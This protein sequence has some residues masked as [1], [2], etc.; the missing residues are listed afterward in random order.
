MYLSLLAWRKLHCERE[1]TKEQHAYAYM[2]VY[3]YFKIT[4]KARYGRKIG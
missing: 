4:N 3:V 2:P 1:A